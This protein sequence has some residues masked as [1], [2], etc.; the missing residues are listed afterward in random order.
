M[1]IKKEITN[2]TFLMTHAIKGFRRP[3]WP[4]KYSRFY[5][6]P[7]DDD[8]R[9]KDT[10]VLSLVLGNRR[11]RTRGAIVS[12]EVALMLK[13]LGIKLIP[14]KNYG[15][16]YEMGFFTLSEINVTK[17][18]DNSS[19]NRVELVRIGPEDYKSFREGDY[20]IAVGTAVVSRNFSNSED[21]V[22]PEIPDFVRLHMDITRNLKVKHLLDKSNLHLL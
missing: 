10:T 9:Y 6:R 21:V 20:F 18:V 4:D 8:E 19:G 14:T 7:D 1:A 13:P 2:G 12:R 3:L 22:F 5:R 16:I 17:S 15:E 11:N